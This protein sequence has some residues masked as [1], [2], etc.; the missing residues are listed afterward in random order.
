MPNHRHL[1]LFCF[2]VFTAR[3]EDIRGKVLDPT[4]ASVSQA[5]VTLYPASGTEIRKTRTTAAG[6]FH[7]ASVS[8][9][10]YLLEVDYPGFSAG[11][12]ARVIAG[13][14][15]FIEIVLD[16]E[17]VAQKVVV[18]ASGTPLSVDSTAKALDVL[19]YA[20]MQR[21]A[22]FSLSEVLRQIP[23]LRVQQLG[24][25]GAFTRVQTR[26]L[27]A[28][29]TSVLIDGFRMR[30]AA[31]PQGDASGFLSDLLVVN[32]E[33]VEV[34]R[35]SG[36]S[37]YGTHAIA[38]VVQVITD[39][40]GGPLHGEVSTEGG[41]L[42]LFR[43]LARFGGSGLKDRLQF[44]GGIA[45][46]NVT[47]GVD[48][49][50]RA[51]NS[52]FQ[53]YLQYRLGARTRLNARLWASNAFAGLNASPFAGPAVNFASTGLIPAIPLAANQVALADAGKPF[54]FGAATFAPSLNDPDSRR[55]STQTSGL[56]GFTH[57]LR[58]G[59]SIRL[60]YQGLGTSRD[61]RD[62]PGGVR[63]P[64]RFNNAALFSGRLDNIEARVDT[65]WGRHQLI[66]AGYEFEKEWFESL[67]TDQ[68]PNPAQ[69]VFARTSVHQRAHSVF[70]QDQI[71]LL[72]D[73]LMVSLSGRWQSFALRSRP[74]FEG[75]APRYAAAELSSPP[76][77][78]TGDIAIAYLLPSR[79]TKVRAHMGNAY[80][81]PALYERFGTS[82]FS[83]SFSPLGDPRLS[84]ERSV[85]FDGG[86]DQ[87]FANS[88][89]RV[90]ATY[91]YTRLQNV[92][93]FGALQLGRDPF[94]RFSGYLN[95]RGGLARGAELSGEAALLRGMRIMGSY[96]Y[97]RAQ[98]RTPLFADGLLLSPRVPRHLGTFLIAQRI[99]KRI[100]IT[101][102]AAMSGESVTPFFAGTGTRA[103]L[104]PGARKV[105]LSAS[106]TLP[107]SDR[108]SLQMYTRID[109]I[110]N[111]TWYEDGFRVP[112]AW[113]VGGLRLLF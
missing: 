12:P 99:G 17:R 11:P 57:E 70:A 86:F 106:Y 107:V 49:D 91:F 97:A 23:G 65:R 53:G 32:P 104:F 15:D 20:G 28:T 8:S 63:F 38:G 80:R 50:D 96:T 3:A 27:R 39:Q 44:S 77:A 66:T 93:S 94:D 88:R 29:D 113:A 79:G 37:L 101:V 16:L 56:L 103:F 34:L 59:T 110:L 60:S 55:L 43:G 40:G 13:K 22:E 6:E 74:E 67:S 98:E 85:A 64:P 30:D 62:G 100:D 47:R 82:F 75:A 46:L 35:G 51:R 73:R 109:N 31:A 4:R 48:G 2:A 102:D 61:N 9:G 105:D 78:Y 25:P 54:S 41:G 36:S 52:S 45:H 7:F 72:N 90:S 1:Y 83:G 33:R 21:R 58:P 69:R 14:T 89:A 84:P 71:R 5:W 18:T 95:T 112:K 111:Q 10:E 87:Y 81:A 76:D 108:V 26:G 92:I 42:G 19:D 68:N 24:G